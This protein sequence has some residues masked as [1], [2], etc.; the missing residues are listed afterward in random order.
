MPWNDKGLLKLNSL[1]N[2]VKN[3]MTQYN[4]SLS[5][6]VKKVDNSL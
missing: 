2:L 3:Y 6:S 5:L 1:T 4:F